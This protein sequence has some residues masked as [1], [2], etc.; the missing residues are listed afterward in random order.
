MELSEGL[1]LE[2]LAGRTLLHPF[3]CHG[4]HNDLPRSRRFNWSRFD[5]QLCP[6][7]LEVANLIAAN[8]FWPPSSEYMGSGRASHTLLLQRLQIT[9]CVPSQLAS[10]YTGD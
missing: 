8:P 7:D 1:V 3:K 5:R 2:V 9:A 10:D 6:I 4:Y